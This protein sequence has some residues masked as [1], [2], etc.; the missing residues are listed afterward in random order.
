MFLTAGWT[1][2]TIWR[3]PF[4]HMTIIF[5]WENIFQILM[6]TLKLWTYSYT[7]PL[8]DGCG[9]LLYVHVFKNTILL[10]N[11]WGS[12]LHKPVLKLFWI[13]QEIILVPRI[14]SSILWVKKWVSPYRDDVPLHPKSWR[15]FKIHC[16][17]HLNRQWLLV[18]LFLSKKTN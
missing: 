4:G 18:L 10:T 5:F 6:T 2:E 16:R 12:W 1:K 8:C 13:Y 14:V 3:W 9:Q 7:Q 11:W 15:F 17:L